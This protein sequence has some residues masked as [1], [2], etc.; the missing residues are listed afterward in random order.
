MQPL[1][2]LRRWLEKNP[3]AADFAVTAGAFFP[4]LVSVIY[5][6]DGTR[7]ID[8]IGVLL[9]FV[10]VGLVLRRRYEPS[11][12]L[13]ITAT[14]GFTYWV[15][16]YPGGGAVYA[17]MALLYASAR[18]EPNRRRARHALMAFTIGL[19]LVLTAG[20]FSANEGDV[21]IG[22]II[23]NLIIFQLIWLVGD[24]VRERADSLDDLRRAADKTD[25]EIAE[26]AERAVTDERNRIARELHDIMAHSLSVV[27]V[28]AEGARR[29]VGSDDASVTEALETIEQTARAN[30]GDIRG[31][32]GLLRAD[33]DDLTP[34]PSVAM[35]DQLVENYGKTGLKVSLD[36]RGDERPL[37]AMVD[38]SAYRIVQESLTNTAKH[39]GPG[40]SA[41][42]V[43]AYEP[44]SLC[45]EIT[46][47]GRGTANYPSKIGHGLIGMRERVDA[48]GGKLSS[49]PK[50]GGGFHVEARLPVQVQSVQTQSVQSQSSETQST[51]SP[52]VQ[53]Q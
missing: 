5:P 12:M 17:M 23:V 15:A 31:L 16:D 36:I 46:D 20:Y 10:P 43:V 27:V 28:Q 9:A 42:V 7:Q 37:P 30:L 29:L 4:T 51:R 2:S 22:M 13:A 26:R 48:F 47:D 33:N 40:A 34:T 11:L 44:D 14:M 45:I 50:I 8:A 41:A 3:I 19:L 53:S 25:H 49:G 32:V 24:T 6:D 38:L 1:L 35:I 18:F 39:A 52:S 21:S